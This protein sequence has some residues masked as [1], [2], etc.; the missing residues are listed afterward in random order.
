MVSVS[1]A[2]SRIKSDLEPHLPASSVERA[3][4]EAGHRWRERKLGP[5]ATLQLFVL[6]VLHCNTAIRHLRHLAKKPVN[7]AAY[8]KAR[9]RLPLAA[10]QALLRSS[11]QVMRQEAA[12][13]CEGGCELWC[14][15]RPFLVDGTGTITPDTPALQKEFG[16]PANQKPG[17]GLPVPKL[18]ALFDA[19]SGMVV[20]LL[21]LPL[22]SHDLRGAWRLHPLLV[23]GDLLVGDRGFCSFGH[24]A[25]LH[26]RGVLACF[27]MHQR[28]IVDFR[29]HRR[30]GGAGR[31][32]RKGKGRRRER[33][34]PSS[35]FVRRLGHW[36]QLVEWVR[37]KTAP[38][39]MTAR[40]LASLPPT[41]AVRELRYV[42]KQQGMR[43]RRVTLATTLL[44]PAAYPKD[45]VA[46]LYGTRWRVETHF[47]QLKTT[48]KMRRLKSTTPQGVR[49]EL[50]VYCLVFNL[51][52]AVMARAA[53]R[54]DTTPDRVSFLDTLRWLLSAEPGEDLP[55]LVVNKRRGRHEPRVVKDLQDTYRKM[56]LPRAEMKKQPAN[57]RGRPK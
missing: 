19:F 38:A 50:A 28:V 43:P 22:Y 24:L 51:V 45:K 46:E 6:Q 39:W 16:Q 29:P 4:R 12:G 36:D 37:P 56:V 25:L 18:L 11:S 17:C 23:A 53:A 34:L 47:A 49:K 21:A 30:H 9:M 31:A 54:Q 1:R 20:E 32:K 48:L 7:A 15:L 3:C 10:V 13:S 8:C 40:Q 2:L 5:V 55:D 35:R 41:L 33:G 57:W 14:G 27:H 26:L 52:H 42:V 44:D